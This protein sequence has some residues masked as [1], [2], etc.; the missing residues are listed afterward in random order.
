MYLILYITFRILTFLFI[1]NVFFILSTFY[2]VTHTSRIHTLFYPSW[3]SMSNRDKY[4]ICVNYATKRKT[5]LI[6][7]LHYHFRCSL[8]ELLFT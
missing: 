5:L 6:Y 3:H 7:E 2:L 4:N 1:F 8:L